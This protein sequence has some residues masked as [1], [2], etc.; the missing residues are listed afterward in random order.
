MFMPGQPATKAQEE[1]TTA[2]AGVEPAADDDDN[3]RESEKRRAKEVRRREK[4]ERRRRRAEAA[5]VDRVT[6][7][8]PV[9]GAPTAGA[10]K[11]HREPG[12][13]DGWSEDSHPSGAGGG[14]A[15]GTKKRK[16]CDKDKKSAKHR[17]SEG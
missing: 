10:K 5:Q 9:D 7:D 13:P 4:E 14:E 3:R 16:K 8:V 6:V 1:N 11:E 15:T 12:A 17:R 2:K